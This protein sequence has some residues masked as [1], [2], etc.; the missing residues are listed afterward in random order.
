M[1]PSSLSPRAIR[2]GVLEADLSSS[3][4]RKSGVRVKL[5]AQPFQVL[6]VL[7]QHPG[8]LVTRQQLSKELWAEYT[9]VDSEQGLATAISK[10]RE[11]LGD[12]AD[13]PRYVETLPRRG[14]RFIANV[15]EIDTAP[16]P[17]PELAASATTSQA[18]ERTKAKRR[19]WASARNIVVI[20]IVVVAMAL[21]AIWLRRTQSHASTGI[22]SIAVLPWDSL[23]G[24]ASQD[25]FADGMTDELITE[26]GQI[27]SLRVIS[28]TS[29]M[30][31]KHA[32]ESLPQIARELKVDAIVEGTIL[33]S[34]DRVRITAQLIEASAD[35]H[36]WAEN[37]EGDLRDTLALQNK[38]ARTVAEKIRIELTPREKAVDRK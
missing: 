15:T 8:E 17:K 25:Y 23:S 3:E 18:A 22:R 34:G 14:Y 27:T 16:G 29:V 12:S 30:R 13:N 9:F 32:H 37:Y 1:P 28:R 36:L 31:Y 21:T 10:I 19:P 2:F 5:H 33:R 20:A 26:L 24:D 11:A 35:R 4:L 7:L 6:S 38:V